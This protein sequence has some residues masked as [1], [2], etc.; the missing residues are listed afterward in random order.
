MCERELERERKRERFV[1]ILL[2]QRDMTAQRECESHKSMYLMN[3][4]NLSDPCLVLNGTNLSDHECYDVYHQ[5]V[6]PC[7]LF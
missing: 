2:F 4:T 1:N 6:G 5:S 7:I 3:C